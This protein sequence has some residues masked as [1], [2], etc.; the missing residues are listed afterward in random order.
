M[1]MSLRPLLV[2]TVEYIVASTFCAPRLILAYFAFHGAWSRGAR[3][4]SACS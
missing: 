3:Q 1:G 2:L 4:R